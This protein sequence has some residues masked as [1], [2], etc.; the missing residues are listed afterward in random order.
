MKIFR[1]LGQTVLLFLLINSCF[2]AESAEKL[3]EIQLNGLKSLQANFQQTI[4]AADDRVLQES[5]GTMALQRPGKFRWKVNK[6]NKQLIIANN[7]K[8]WVYDE[9]LAQVTIQPV[10]KTHN[11]PAFLLSDDNHDLLRKFSVT[12]I[13]EENATRKSFLL[14]P[15]QKDSMFSS[16]QL[17]FKQDK[18]YQ[19]IMTDG[20]GQITTITLTA[21]KINPTFSSEQFILRVPAGVEVINQI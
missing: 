5:S 10:S 7:N 13:K 16:L 11:T 19:I 3:L 18:L 21:I 12:Q 17:V 20:L 8:L 14:Q 15:K 6:P 1:Y 2:A 4:R 9:D